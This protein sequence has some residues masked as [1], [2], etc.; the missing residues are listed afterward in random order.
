ME[1]ELINNGYTEHNRIT[2]GSCQGSLGPSAPARTPAGTFRTGCSRSHPGSSW[3]SPSLSG[4]LCLCSVTY[5]EKKWFPMFRQNLLCS[6]LFLFSHIT[7]MSV[8]SFFLPKSL[9][10]FRLGVLVIYHF[11]ENV[12]FHTWIQTI[13]V[14]CSHT[15]FYFIP[16]SNAC[17]ALF[18]EFSRNKFL[19]QAEIFHICLFIYHLIK[20][21]KLQRII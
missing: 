3:R 11:S 9:L 6:S 19:L 2:E 1:Y 15:D 18:V 13:M 17:W 7:E 4:N 8:S 10:V 20:F 5:T 21:N 16:S 12:F 14:I